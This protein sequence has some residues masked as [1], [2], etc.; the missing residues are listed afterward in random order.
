ML[1]VPYYY[2]QAL[3]SGARSLATGT[4]RSW[5]SNDVESP[6]QELAASN[7]SKP[8]GPALIRLLVE[9]GADP[10]AYIRNSKRCIKYQ[11]FDRDNDLG[12]TTGECSFRIK[13]ATPSPYG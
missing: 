12:I 13:L 9:H 7:P 6:L 1:K 5:K 3:N 8:E 10:R 2:I 11:D 4:S